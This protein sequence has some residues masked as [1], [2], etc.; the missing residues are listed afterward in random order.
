M[1]KELQP[2][3]SGIDM[4]KKSFLSPS[5]FLRQDIQ[6]QFTENEP[7]GMYLIFALLM[8]ANETP[9]DTKNRINISKQLTLATGQCH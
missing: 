1:K 5:G 3:V 8:V 2:I 7:P 6:Y 9:F 4:E